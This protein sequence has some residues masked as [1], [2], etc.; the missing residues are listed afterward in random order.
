MSVTK[1]IAPQFQISSLVTYVASESKPE[2]AY[3]FFSYKISIENKGSSPA[4]LMSRHWYI[5]DGNGKIEEVRGPGVVGLQPK[6]YPEQK[7]EYESACPLETSW[8]TMKGIYHFLTESG[9][10]FS[11]EIPEFHLISP[12]ALH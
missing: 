4:Q 1:S 6:I 7:F 11:V 5:Q 10:T 12:Q 8:G 3:Y 2:E 9:E